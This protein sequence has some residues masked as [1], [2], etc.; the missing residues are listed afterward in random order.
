[1]E[2]A[3][4]LTTLAPVRGGAA[5]KPEKPRPQHEEMETDMKITRLFA[6]A[7]LATASVTT[8]IAPALA[9]PPTAPGQTGSNAGLLSFCESILNSGDYGDALTFGLCMSFNNVSDAGYVTQVCL[10]FRGQGLLQEYGFDSFDD[11]VS[12]LQQTY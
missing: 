3:R 1:M 7:A 5:E 8:P 4:A 11:C 6:A 2:V 12:T 9:D 10:A